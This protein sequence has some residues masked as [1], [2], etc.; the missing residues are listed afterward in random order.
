MNELLFPLSTILLVFGAVIPFLSLLTQYRIRF[1]QDS[2]PTFESLYTNQLLFWLL[3]PTMLPIVW[4]CLSLGH[5]LYFHHIHS[6]HDSVCLLSHQHFWTDESILL[7]L[8]V[9][10]VIVLV[11]QVL[12]VEQ[13]GSWKL[14]SDSV[15]EKRVNDLCVQEELGC[16]RQL[17]LVEQSVAAQS[18]GILRP[19][20]LLSRDWVAQID[21]DMLKATIL[22]EIAHH[23]AGDL[24]M[25]MILKI[26]L[27][28]NIHAQKLQSSISIWIQSREILADK[29]SVR[30]GAEPLALAQAIVNAIRWQRSQPVLSSYQWGIRGENVSLVKLRLL[31]LTSYDD[32]SEDSTGWQDL[33]MLCVLMLLCVPHLL[34]IDVLDFVHLSIEVLAQK[35]GLIP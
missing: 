1:L 8:I 26:G 14:V 12:R 29:R 32:S 18:V 7:A 10:I 28:L 34:S 19:K 2:S 5:L 30:L 20:I 24:W 22:H 17:I 11:V 35:Y 33:W 27:M 16:F 23:Q 13:Q 6:S 9:G 4:I 15:I 21:D 25:G 3:L 31:Q